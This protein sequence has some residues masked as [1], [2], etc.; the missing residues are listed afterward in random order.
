MQ[1]DVLP[2]MSSPR[3]MQSWRVSEGGS[4]AQ[5]VAWLHHRL[6]SLPME[7]VDACEPLHATA[8]LPARVPS[9]GRC[10]ACSSG[11]SSLHNSSHGFHL[12]FLPITCRTSRRPWECSVS[13][14]RNTALHSDTQPVLAAGQDF[15]SG[16]VAREDVD[17]TQLVGRD[18]AE[19]LGDRGQAQQE[20]KQLGDD[21]RARGHRDR[22]F[23]RDRH[24][25]RAHD[26]A[27]RLEDEAPALAALG[28]GRALEV[29]EADVRARLGRIESGA[30]GRVLDLAR[31]RPV[32]P[33]HVEAR[34]RPR[35]DLL[36]DLKPPSDPAERAERRRASRCQLHHRTLPPGAGAH[37]RNV[38]VA[39]ADKKPHPR[40]ELLAQARAE[41]HPLRGAV[42]A[43]E[44]YARSTGKV[45]VVLV[46]SGPGAANAAPAR[47]IA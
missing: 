15:Q 18:T 12:A 29:L 1:S 6:P 46:T 3:F 41:G 42:H 28:L 37:E 26:V 35:A 34:R 36:R 43:A 11:G 31:E 23:R 14:Q 45:G 16:F 4:F 19:V 47:E 38:E 10:L 40:P 20:R 24:G 25:A 8:P 22:R 2:R 13:T 17:G 9:V 7:R 44:G 21:R 30:Q 32:G 27:R 5:R 39:A 33:Q